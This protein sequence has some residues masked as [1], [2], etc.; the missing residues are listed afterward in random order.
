[1]STIGPIRVSSASL[2]VRALTLGAALLAACSRAAPPDARA[3]LGERR[4]SSLLTP[5]SRP[6]SAGNGLH[7]KLVCQGLNSATGVCAGNNAGAVNSIATAV[8]ALNA[9]AA[10][11]VP[12]SAPIVFDW[13]NGTAV[14]WTDGTV[15]TAGLFSVDQDSSLAWGMVVHQA[16]ALFSGYVAIPASAS[17]T[18]KTFAVGSQDGFKLAISGCLAS[19]AT[20]ASAN[21]QALTYLQDG[22]R[23]FAY[24]GTPSD[25]S[26]R[27]VLQVKFPASATDQLYPLELLSYSAATAQGLELAWADGAQTALPAA[28]ALGGYALVPASSLYAPNVRA[29]MWAVDPST[30]IS[31][32]DKITISVQIQNLGAV[33]SGALQLT[34]ATTFLT[35]P[36]VPTGCSASSGGSPKTITCSGLAALAAGASVQLQFGGNLNGNGG[37]PADF[38]AIITGAL[39]APEIASAVGVAAGSDLWNMTDDLNATASIFLSEDT[40]NTP[41]GFNNSYGLTDDDPTRLSPGKAAPKPATISAVASPQANDHAVPVSGTSNFPQG[42]IVTVHGSS[43]STTKTCNATTALDGSWAC[44]LVLDEGSWSLVATE[45]DASGLTGQPSAAVALVITAPAAPTLSLPLANGLFRSGAVSFSGT[46]AQPIN[47]QLLVTA[48]G[49]ATKTCLAVADAGGNWSCSVSGLADGSWS[50]TAAVIEVDGVAGTAAA[51]RSFTINSVFTA[52]SIAQTTTPTK[53][54]KPTLGGTLPAGES[55]TGW[56]LTVYDGS[57]AL[58]GCTAIAVTGTTWA[59]TL[60]ASLPDG[61][62][63][64]VASLNDPYGYQSGP[65]SPSDNFTVDTSTPAAPTFSAVPTPTSNAQPVFSGTGVLSF[66]VTV[67]NGATTVCTATVNSAGVWGCQPSAALADGSYTLGASQTNLVGTTGPVASRSFVVD[68]HVPVTPGLNALASPSTNATPALAGT[69]EPGDVLVVRDGGGRALCTTSVLIGGTWTCASASLP[70]GVS[71]LR[72]ASTSSS[73]VPSASSAPVSVTI[74]TIP[75]AAPVLSQTP[76]PS[77]NTTPF[78]SG[79]AEPASTVSVFSGTTLL[80]SA[81]ANATGAFNCTSAVVLNG[82]P[83]TYAATARAS[84]ASGNV[85][86]FSN[87]D[88][89]TVDTRPPPAPVLD[90][91]PVASGG[92]PG[93]SSS[94]Q[95]TFTGTGTPGD[96]I[97]VVE[98]APSSQTLCTAVVSGSGTWSCQSTVVLVSGTTY[99]LG[100][101]QTSLA[102]VS[103]GS[104]SIQVLSIDN[105]VP[106]TPTLAALASPTNN[107]SP[108]LSGIGEA[109]SLVT[110]RDQTGRTVCSATVAA[111]GTWSCSGAAL[112]DGSATL[113]ATATSPSGVPSAGSS[114]GTILIDTQRPP[115]PS[116]AQTASPTN[117]TQ[118][119]FSGVA[120]PASSVAVR[121]GTAILCATTASGSGAFSCQVTAVL[122]TSS[123]AVS[124]TAADAAGNVSD[125]SAVD[126]FSVDAAAP[127]APAIDPLPA[128][129]GGVAGFTSDVRPL[130]TG[131]GLAGDG[132]VVSTS[133]GQNLCTTTVLASGAWGCVSALALTGAPATGYIVSAAQQSAVGPAS[134]PSNPISFVVDTHVPSVPSLAALASPTN[135]TAPMLSGLGEPASI[136]TVRDQTGRALCSATVAPDGTWQCTSASLPDGTATLTATAVSRAGVSSP[137]SAAAQ[138]VVDTLPPPAPQLAQTSSLTS[139]TR[140]VFSGVAEPGSAVSVLEGPAVLCSTSAGTG[141]VFSCQSTVDLTG[142]PQSHSVT[143]IASDA[144]RNQS[145]PSAPDAFVVDTTQPGAPTLDALP[146][147]ADGQPGYTTSTQPVFS[148]TGTAGDTLTVS[149]SGGGKLCIALVGAD[150]SWLCL[151]GVVL[152]GSPPASYTVVATQ[153]SPAFVASPQSATL[154]FTVDTETPGAPTLDAV[155]SPSNAATPLL[156]GTADKGSLLQVRDQTG[157][158]VCALAPVAASGGWS[159]TAATLPDGTTVLSAISK[160][161]A[162]VPS[163]PSA[164]IAVVVDTQA[165]AAPSLGQTPTPTSDTL[166][167]F[168][169]RAEPGSTVMLTEGGSPL[170]TA[171][172]AADGSFSCQPLLALSGAPSTHTVVANATDAA[173]NRSAVSAPDTFV[174]DTTQPAAP[175][176]DAV[177]GAIAQTQPAFSGSGAPGDIVSV[178]LSDGTLLCR[179][180]VAPDRSWS[181]NSSVSLTGN[182]ATAYT[183][184]ATQETPAL[185]VSAASA[186]ASFIVDTHVPAQPV[187]SRLTSPSRDPVPFLSGS[188]EPGDLVGVTDQTGR[189]LCTS[190]VALDGSWG[191]NSAL[192]PDGTSTLTPVQTS[193]EQV[194]SPA[195]IPLSLTI[196]T[197]APAA[198]SLGQTASPGSNTL[199]VFTGSAEPGSNVSVVE[200][201]TALCTAV[202]SPSG[203]FSCTSVLPLT[204]APQRHDV[205]ATAGDAAGNV[206]AASNLD[207]FVVDTSAPAAPVV[208]AQ[209]ASIANTRPT[210]SGVGVAGDPVTVVSGGVV[211]CTA[212]V[213]SDGRWA[214]ISAV[215]LTGSPAT[216]Y[217]VAASQVSPAGV[218]SPASAPVTFTVDTR[219]P[220]IPT[221]AVVPT[222]G[223]NATPL[224][225]GT[226]DPRTILVVRDGTGR[227]LCT[228][229][230]VP[231]VGAWSCTS[232]SLPDGATTLTATAQS[233]AGLVSA[234]SA[235]VS[236]VVDTQAPAAPILAQTSSPSSTTLPTFT[237]TAEAGSAVFVAEGPAV[238]CTTTAAPDGSFSCRTTVALTG[239]PQTHAVTA[240]A[241]DAAG[242]VS[243]ASAVDSF[244]VDTA[245]PAAP[246]L[247]ALTAPAGGLPGF[248]ASLQPGFTGTGLP[249]DVVAVSA[250]APGALALCT[251][252]VAANGSW[253]CNSGPVLTGAPATAYAAS[254]TQ[255]NA[256]GSVSPASADINF[257]VDTQVPSTPTLAKLGSPSRINTPALTGTADPLARIT[258][259]DQTGRVLCTATADAQGAWACTSTALPDAFNLIIAFATSA[260]G[261]PSAASSPAV[262]VIDTQ[263]PAAPSLASTP[264]PGAETF[265]QFTGVAEP[266]SRISVV[267]GNTA[268]CSAIADQSGVFFCQTAV[269]LLGAPQTHAVTATATDPAGNTSAASA[270]DTFVVDTRAVGAPT[271]V[272]VPDPAAAQPGFTASVNPG[273]AGT[274]TAGDLVSVSAGGAVLCTAPVASDGR[275]AC[276]AV[277]ALAAPA[278]YSA[279]ALQTSVSGASAG[280]S[281]VLQFTVDPRPPAAPSLDPIGS[282]LANRAPLVSGNA[283]PGSSVAVRDGAGVVVCSASP[284]AATGRWSCTSAALADGAAM[285]TASATS[286]AG[287]GPVDSAPRSFVVDTQPP[288]APFLA[289]T[290]SPGNETSPVFAGTAEP[291]SL[292]AVFEGPAALCTV[293]AATDGTFSCQA[294]A[295]LGGAPQQHTVT[296]TATD[297]A[298]NA[299]LPSAPDTFIIDLRVPGATSLDPVG[300]TASVTVETQ[301]AFS[302]SGTAGDRVA[303]TEIAP[304]AAVLCATSV[305]ADGTWSCSSAVALTG[306]PLTAYTVS[307]TETTQAGQST[308]TAPRTFAVDSHTPAAPSLDA[309]ASPTASHQPQLTGTAEALAQVEIVDA[310]GVL[311]ATTTADA[312]GFFA[313]APLSP[314][315]DGEYQLSARQTAS[316]GLHSPFSSPVTLSVRSLTVPTLDAPPSP[317]RLVSPVL[318]GS[319]QPGL[320]V[321]VVSAQAPLCSAI[322]SPSGSWSCQPAPLA[323]GAYSLQAVESD[324]AGHQSGVSAARWVVIDRTKP[325]APVLDA[326]RTPSTDPR[327]VV[328]G[329]AEA[330]SVVTVHDQAAAVVCS[331]TASAAGVFSCAPGAALA[332]GRYRFTATATDSASNVSDPSA[333]VVFD[334]GAP[335]AAP[336]ISSP[337]DGASLPASQVAIRGVSAGAARVRV[338]LDGVPFE[339]QLGANGQWLLPLSSRLAAGQHTLIAVAVDALGLESAEARSTFT[340]EEVLVAGP[341][342]G[343]GLRVQGGCQSGGVPS[344]LLAVMALLLF[345]RVRRRSLVPARAARH[346]ARMLPLVLLSA[347]SAAQAQV[348]GVDVSLFRPASGSD[349]FTSVE[350][351]RPPE[352]ADLQLKLWGDGARNPLMVVSGDGTRTAVVQHRIGAWLSGQTHLL[353]PLSLAVQVPMTVQ[354]SGDL[355]LLGQG[356]SLASG[357]G[358]LRLTPRVALLRQRSGGVDAAVQATLELPTA[359]A[360]SLTGDDRVAGQLLLAVGRRFSFANAV[361]II[362]VVGNVSVTLRPPRDIADVRLGNELGLAMAAALY[363]VRSVPARV[364]AE[365]EA[366][367][368]LRSAFSSAAAPAE[369]RLGGSLCLWRGLTADLA[370]GAGLNHGVGAPAGRLVFGLGWSA[371]GCAPPEPDGV[372]MA[373]APPQVV[374]RV[375][376]REVV[377]EVVKE[378]PQACAAPA[379]AAA[380]IAEGAKLV[381]KGKIYFD[382]GRATLKA[383][384]LSV[385]DDA[386]EQVRS[387]PEAKKLRIEG[388][389]DDRG[390]A[391]RNLSISQ[392]RAEAVVDYLVQKGVD[393]QRLVAQGFGRTQPVA[394]NSTAAGRELNRRVEFRVIESAVE[395]AAQPKS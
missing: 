377:R 270:A 235:P 73:G 101:V 47:T 219:T 321:T 337:A 15:G 222:P 120:E 20:C 241:R 137:P 350:G 250:T 87:T 281:G 364:F 184:V 80:C 31:N 249:G 366:R 285:L 239:A 133:T 271:L 355:S 134:S 238:L 325:A 63:A 93:I 149:L 273:F 183:V 197:Q 88:S 243:A 76:T 3:S 36:T 187:L 379:L 157:R 202:A 158:I 207:S 395:S 127:A 209:P 308:T 44:S 185:V 258:A 112:P 221:I 265:P 11:S 323:D 292:V 290:A 349:G 254:A 165:P 43:G 99:T 94:T 118:P 303:L 81:V 16:P 100:A 317:T 122:A 322:V 154:S 223:N 260:A 230:S 91:Q 279:A 233:P 376:T 66:L 367:G 248:T 41:L 319:G 37:L 320:T 200:G 84:D 23:T 30:T 1:L 204:G 198:P 148:G 57:T 69:G 347:G 172:A 389:T 13:V 186:P 65:S 264:S 289:Q 196:D 372:G 338:I 48:T 191:C 344:P 10:P 246:T 300:G 304:A 86:P 229:G 39:T 391:A 390:S 56:T 357:F 190:M 346:A 42:S 104:S 286:A 261:L 144:A 29:T 369:W 9:P 110:V 305:R 331:A 266:G 162:G 38:Q 358:N 98:S 383:R 177:P 138:V 195:G 142:A 302:G 25:G 274:G 354:Q 375:V 117:D 316:N 348:P 312:S 72:A 310:Y 328:S 159:C 97:A 215:A 156:T 18:T 53:S 380:P 216:S 8:I 194:R 242:N 7:V 129:A 340:V 205:T 145:A 189:V 123:H 324:G 363:P 19:A 226:A 220:G 119:F 210:F 353:G 188:G 114:S 167:V 294:A 362:E 335:P 55:G 168:S 143:A 329:M 275:W 378:V 368:A 54:S 182:P 268:L 155:P 126:A 234:P 315:P 34:F 4:T 278:T 373:D 49:A 293:T 296:A 128:P 309:P 262:V 255:R 181:C 32:G 327:P 339:A 95:P 269:A 2:T 283:D 365:L 166:P 64:L 82:A 231:A 169:G 108:A 116:L 343:G 386:L 161:P 170:C 74:D 131:T 287:L 259:A 199:P 282:P 163:A 6:A 60:T 211:L 387:H 299:S 318:T 113:T 180:L 62:H 35:A 251:A 12:L 384:S 107:P 14:D 83:Q 59:C 217:S 179:A 68:T 164:S 85:G 263:A 111:G 79:S 392:A 301:P 298:L 257:T 381:L 52:P 102:G 152:S 345:L 385:L 33:S 174:L 203:T 237:G 306:V 214:C 121:E 61:T 173:G 356:G 212:I 192:L 360:N 291:G 280:Q 359:K 342:V 160:S 105:H 253:A 147:P 139:V 78:F 40:G 109:G 393:R 256:A 135:D 288:A 89:F 5:L 245:Q 394:P 341:P 22:T 382:A 175:Q 208:D 178:A 267:E 313:A 218:T 50:W 150:G 307:A 124:A 132:L 141:G 45:T 370:A 236:L 28:G 193:Q 388:Y 284:V 332:A 276:S 295:A 77:A 201:A 326:L 352:A 371:A 115:A 46:T 51:S 252:T 277:A 206:S 146:L 361:P 334:E 213:G 27:T 232:A 24:G 247:D 314:F 90:P 103:S 70:D 330:L 244:V 297:A 106:A 374:E 171:V 26:G 136:V 75:P 176:L 311:R 227:V 130:F 224:L 228:V 272:L 96:T 351:A 240:T 125:P 140:P 58:A 333:E 17:V 153:Q 21:L 92:Q 71:T 67:A 151:S 336:V 225:S